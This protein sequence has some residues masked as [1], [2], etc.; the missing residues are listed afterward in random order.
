MELHTRTHHGQAWLAEALEGAGH[1]PE[2]TYW[3]MRLDLKD[4]RLVGSAPIP[5]DAV[6]VPFDDAYDTL[7]LRARNEIFADNRGSVPMTARTWRHSVTGSPYFRPDS[8]FLLL[9]EQHREILCCLL[10]TEIA[11]AGSGNDRELY[12]AN[13]GTR[14]ALHGRGLYRAVFTHTLDRAKTRGY[15]WAVLDVDSTNPMAAGGFYDRMGLRRFRTWTA[16]VLHC[17]PPPRPSSPEDA[18]GGA[19]RPMWHGPVQ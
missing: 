18:R 19:A 7:L 1:R 2:R 8:S 16:H 11:D 14:P 5:N 10:C 17:T 3:G 12:L 15:R 9:P 6:I 13:A 4:H